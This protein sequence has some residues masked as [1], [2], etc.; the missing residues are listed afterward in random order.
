MRRLR[1]GRRIYRRRFRS[2]AKALRA[3][4]DVSLELALG[5]TLGLVGESGSGKSTLAKLLLGLLSPDAGGTIE[6]DGAALPA[7]CDE[8]Q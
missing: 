8:P 7:R 3:V 6:L 2:V 1:C 5:E 4:H